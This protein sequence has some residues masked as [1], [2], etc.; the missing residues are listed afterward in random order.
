M[1]LNYMEWQGLN[2]KKIKKL[3]ELSPVIIIKNFFDSY[4]FIIK[5]K[6]I[7]LNE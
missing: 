2:M 4:I 3:F 5:W 1:D 6:I 7:N